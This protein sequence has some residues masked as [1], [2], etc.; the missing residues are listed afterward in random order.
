MTGLYN[1]DTG[2]RLVND[3]LDGKTGRAALRTPDD[4]CGPL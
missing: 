4:G 1:H 3:Y 2:K